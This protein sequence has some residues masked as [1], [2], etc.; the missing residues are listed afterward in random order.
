MRFFQP[1]LRQVSS[2]F[3]HDGYSPTAILLLRSSSEIRHFEQY[4]S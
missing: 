2:L 3:M 4:R 1:W